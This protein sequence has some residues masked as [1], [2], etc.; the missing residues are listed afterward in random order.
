MQDAMAAF[1][2]PKEKNDP[3]ARYQAYDVRQ[4]LVIRDPEP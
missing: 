2:W 3:E 1:A 4:F